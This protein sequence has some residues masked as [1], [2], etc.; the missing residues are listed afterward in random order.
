MAGV[1]EA[2]GFPVWRRD[3]RELFYRA[4]DGKLMSVSVGTGADF[5]PVRPNPCS[6]RACSSP[7]PAAERFYDV[8][9]DAVSSST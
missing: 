9:P 2:G 4:R 3:G 6:R 5:E 7:A 8:A 1:G